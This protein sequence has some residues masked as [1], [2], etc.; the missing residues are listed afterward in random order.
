MP[1]G[2]ARVRFGL[3]GG[4]AGSLAAGLTVG[5]WAGP[6]LAKPVEITFLSFFVTKD[7]EL[8]RSIISDFERANPDIKVNLEIMSYDAVAEQTITRVAG[9]R[10]PDVIDLHP[11]DFYSF[12]R[13]GLLRDLTAWAQRDVD[14][15]DFFP[16][17]LATV[18]VDGRIYALPQRIS[19]YVLFY[20]KSLFDG[21]GLPYP[22]KDWRDA[23]WNWDA[24]REASRKLKQDMNGDG[25]V[26]RFG[27]VIDTGI[28]RKLLTFLFQSGGTIFDTEYRN[29]LLDREEALR[30]FRYVQQ[31][32]REEL[33][34]GSF[35]KGTAGMIV[36]IPPS[37]I[38]F[39]KQVAFEFDVAALP[40]GPAGPGTT[41]QPIPV[42]VVAQ[43][44]NPEAAWAFLRFY[45][46]RPTSARHSQAG[47]IVQPRR[48]V[49]ANPENYPKV[50]VR[51][52]L[53]FIGALEVGRPVPNL[54]SKF[55]EIAAMINQALTPV[56]RGEKDPLTA[57]QEIKGPVEAL[58]RQGR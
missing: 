32:F 44:K 30:A 14:L 50:G 1:R 46:S 45:M 9:G 11:K 48:S 2:R 5:L 18:R 33:F 34:G 53:P 36:D 25:K 56:W 31:G 21:A 10:P 7:E 55:P 43:S 35:P 49:T 17:V 16:P 39:H 42:G 20:N 27:A 26:D 8:A 23:R 52:L 51:D 38:D 3:A 58:L 28:E 6:V 57:I 41:L 19:T 37:M 4:L 22:A 15:N 24:F 12:V 47:V 29:L 13:Q 54:H 40:Q